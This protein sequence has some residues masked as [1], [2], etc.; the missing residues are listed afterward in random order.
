MY[1]SHFLYPFVN[2]HLAY[3]RESM[4][5]VFSLTK[6]VIL[7]DFYLGFSYVYL[8]YSLFCPSTHA[9][10]GLKETVGGDR[11][12]CYLDCGD[13]CMSVCKCPNLS[14]CVHYI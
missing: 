5:Y 11:C 4:W 13:R 2:G 1:I 9:Y 14:N 3:K 7:T 10:E 8:Q 6:L 12:V